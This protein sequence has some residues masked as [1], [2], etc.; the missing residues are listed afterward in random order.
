MANLNQK[1]SKT[2]LSG[3]GTEKIIAK[4]IFKAMVKDPNRSFEMK[5]LAIYLEVEKLLPTEFT[6]KQ[7][8]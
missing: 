6:P 2:K 1:M 7:L 4:S 5:S 3:L 8:N